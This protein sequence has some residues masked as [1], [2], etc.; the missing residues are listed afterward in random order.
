[1]NKSGKNRKEI[2]IQLLLDQNVLDADRDDAAMDL[3]EEFDDKSVLD[4]LVQIAQNPKEIEMILN[5]CG[6]SIGMIWAKQN[7]FDEKTY[8]SLSGTARFGVYVVVKS[9]KP[10]WIEQYQL[11][12]D[13]F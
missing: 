1:M 12:K 2:L 6:E 3:G 4:T 13:N 10:E 11:E 5:S 9:R 8:R 7:V